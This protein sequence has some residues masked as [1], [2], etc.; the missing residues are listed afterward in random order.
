MLLIP[1]EK[2]WALDWNLEETLQAVVSGGM[3]VPKK[4]SWG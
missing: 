3:T 4:I 2:V 1:E